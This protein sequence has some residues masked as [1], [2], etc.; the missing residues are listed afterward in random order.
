MSVSFARRILLNTVRKSRC[1]LNVIYSRKTGGT[2]KVDIS[3][4]CKLIIAPLLIHNIIIMFASHR[5]F[6]AVL[7]FMTWQTFVRYSTTSTLPTKGN[8]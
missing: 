5:P 2:A 8:I 1:F 7:V 3:Y 6:L 4:I